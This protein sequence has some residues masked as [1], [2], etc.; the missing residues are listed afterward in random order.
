MGSFGCS[1]TP[2]LAAGFFNLRL[3]NQLIPNDVNEVKWFQK[4]DF[5]HFSLEQ[6]TY[7]CERVTKTSNPFLRSRYSEFL[8]DIDEKVCSKFNKF[9]IGKIV[10][11]SNLEKSQ[12]YLDNDDRLW[13]KK[14]RK[15]GP[16]WL[17]RSRLLLSPTDS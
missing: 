2:L 3:H 17:F 4:Q 10:V 9:E 14:K 6:K 16:S 1:N 7:Y 12:V 11:K 15:Y 13:S 5:S 8:F